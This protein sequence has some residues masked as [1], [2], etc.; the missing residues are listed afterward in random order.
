MGKRYKEIKKEVLL[1]MK[2]RA[3]QKG[4][5]GRAVIHMNVNNDDGFLSEFSVS[6]TPVISS[7][8]AEFIENSTRSI[9]PKEELTLMIHS[10]CID[11]GEKQ[12]YGSAIKEYYLQRYIETE[13]ELKRNRLIVF[14]LGLA[15]VL[16]LAAGI[17]FDYQVGNL[18]WSEVIDIV[19][20]VLLWEATD[21]GLLG[22]RGLRQK[23]KRYLSYL[24]M[25][26][27]YAP[28]NN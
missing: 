23:K 20:W 21:I 1:Q 14:L 7:S 25:N 2:K 24:S 13:E 16:V 6:E 18:I 5:D 11:D 28:T 19:A 15:G 12:V 27:E 17:I 8:V 9:P 4:A 26:V 22:S 3:Y 10:D